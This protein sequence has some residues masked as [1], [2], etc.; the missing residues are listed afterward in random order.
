MFVGDVLIPLFE[1]IA[2]HLNH[3]TILVKA[4]A[5]IA[6]KAFMWVVFLRGRKVIFILNNIIDRY[7][8]IKINDN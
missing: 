3:L 1:C 8:L 4:L 2:Q 7:F 5:F 6:I